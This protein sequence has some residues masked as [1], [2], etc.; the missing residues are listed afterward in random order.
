M[1]VT[2]EEFKKEVYEIEGVEINFYP[3]FDMRTGK[4]KLI[5]KYPY[6]EKAPDNWSYEE[7]MD[8]RVIP[9]LKKAYPEYVKA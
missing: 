8:K 4:K 1:Y 5:P 7:L 9:L 2:Q 3:L 6:D